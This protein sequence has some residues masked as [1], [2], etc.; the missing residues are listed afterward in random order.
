MAGWSGCRVHS[1]LQPVRCLA[2][3]MAGSKEITMNTQRGFWIWVV[4]L[5]AV[6]FGLLTIKEGGTVLFGSESARAAA[7]NYVPFVLWFNFL[8]G[9]VYVI[10]GVGLWALKRWAVWLALVLAIGTL[11]VFAAFGVY[12]F[13]GGAYEMRTVVAMTLR[14]TVWAV[15]A[16]LAYRRIKRTQ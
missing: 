8:A 7:G 6:A 9:F 10:A 1:F 13:M 14:T 16:A 2:A 11:V 3:A 15:I 5:V 12:V 4:S